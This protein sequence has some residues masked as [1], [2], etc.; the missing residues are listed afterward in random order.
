MNWR[1]ARITVLDTETTGLDIATSRIVELGIVTIENGKMTDAFSI[2]LNPREPIPAAATAI[3]GISDEHVCDSLTFQEFCN[4]IAVADILCAYNARFD[5]GMMIAEY[6]RAGVPCPAWLHAD[7]HW[8][9]P[10][11]WAR[12][13]E[14]YAS[15]AGR[16]KLSRVA[17]R[18]GVGFTELAAHR[19]LADCSA[20]GKV[21]DKLAAVPGL[22]PD[23]FDE[24]IMQQRVLS[25]RNDAEFMDWLSKQP[26][27]E[28]A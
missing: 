14:P 9:D 28:A 21:L 1:T 4:D 13:H 3:H 7:A 15:G 6:L 2:L 22:M 10:L 24:L 5:K 8:I 18:L 26:K 25:A 12:A 11:V 20:T 27:R 23:S 16:Y 19:V 17:A